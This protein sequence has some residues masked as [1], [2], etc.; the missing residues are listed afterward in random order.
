V[1]IVENVLLSYMHVFVGRPLRFIGCVTTLV[2]FCCYLNKLIGSQTCCVPLTRALRVTRLLDVKCRSEYIDST[3]S[4][5]FNLS[6]KFI[7]FDPVFSLNQYFTKH[8]AIYRRC[9]DEDVRLSTETQPSMEEDVKMRISSHHIRVS[10]LAT[11]TNIAFQYFG[12][13]RHFYV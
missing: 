3:A 6:W 1:A 2:Q 5:M 12:F 8:R 11:F 10:A 9:S 4:R 7:N 13:M